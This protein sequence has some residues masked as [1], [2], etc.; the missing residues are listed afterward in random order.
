M[1]AMDRIQVLL[2]G[3]PDDLPERVHEVGTLTDLV[4]LPRGRGYEHFRYTGRTRSVGSGAV[5][6][7]QWCARTMIAE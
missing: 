1:V 3:G 4:K 5:P 2:E 6:V 7:F